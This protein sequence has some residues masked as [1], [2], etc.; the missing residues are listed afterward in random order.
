MQN[1]FYIGI[2]VFVIR[3]GKL[4]LGKRREAFGVGEWGLP[5]GHLEQNER[6]TEAARREL[7]EETGMSARD[8]IFENIINQPQGEKHYIQIGFRAEDPKGEPELREPGR[9][10]EWKWFN[11]N[12]F[13]KNIFIA[14]REQIRLFLK[15]E[16]FAE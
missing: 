10:Y 7:D 6:F 11:T 1:D 4:L 2:N 16:S 3:D 13:P 8:F 5:G 9:C 15:K 12:E 14:H